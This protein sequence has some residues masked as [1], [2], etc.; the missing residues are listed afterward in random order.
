MTEQEKFEAV[1]KAP[2][3]EHTCA[4]YTD[5]TLRPSE[6]SNYE[7]LLAW[8]IWEECAAQK[9]AEVDAL[10]KELEQAKTHNV[11]LFDAIKSVLDDEFRSIVIARNAINATTEQVEAYKQEIIAWAKAEQRER[12]AIFVLRGVGDFRLGKEICEAIRNNKE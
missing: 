2:P 7:T 11:M 6:Y 5:K 1:I 4:K 12:D 9:Q 3:Y 10:R 8:H